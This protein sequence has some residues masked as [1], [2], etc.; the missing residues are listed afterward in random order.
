MSLAQTTQ[1]Y[2]M[3]VCRAVEEVWNRGN[4]DILEDLVTTDIVIHMSPE[5][6]YGSEGIKQ[7]YSMLRESF[8]DIHFAIED[9]V[10]EGDRVV[11]RWTARATHT[12]AFQGVP[13]TGRQVSLTGIDIDRFANGK[14]VEC[15]PVADELG[16]MQQLGAIP[17]PEMSAAMATAPQPAAN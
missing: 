15:W 9:Q 3:L 8:P 11:T 4:F 6:I 12:G 14:V 7:F 16:L 17:T 5:N 10:A 1:Q 13:P 2:C